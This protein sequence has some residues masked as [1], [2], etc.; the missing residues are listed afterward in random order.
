MKSIKKEIIHKAIAQ[1]EEIINSYSWKNEELKLKVFEIIFEKILDD[2][3]SIEA[4]KISEEI[5]TTKDDIQKAYSELDM[6]FKILSKKANVK[7]DLLHELFSFRENKLVIIKSLDESLTDK[8]KTKLVC[9]LTLL[10]YKYLSKI[11][12]VLSSDI[13]QNV[14]I[15]GIS[16]SNYAHHIKELIPTYILSEGTGKGTTYKLT[17]PGEKLAISNIENVNLPD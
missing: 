13:K 15:L 3:I 5:T 2:V 6:N 11:E 12:Q 7:L 1:T 14:M 10:G 4:N 9:L 17:I 16:V 8:Q